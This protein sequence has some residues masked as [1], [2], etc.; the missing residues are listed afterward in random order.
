MIDFLKANPYVT[1]EQYMWEWT[2][3]QIKLASFDFTHIEY[4]SE[5]EAEEYRKEK[6]TRKYENPMDF[7]N[8]LNVPIF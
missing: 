8:D 5:K 2:V 1:K 6:N 7:V 4:L 3:P